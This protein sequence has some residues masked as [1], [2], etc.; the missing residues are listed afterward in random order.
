MMNWRIK[1]SM[2]KLHEKSKDELIQM[3]LELEHKYT[4]LVKAVI[5]K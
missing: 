3:L 1:M 5:L 4:D 2:R